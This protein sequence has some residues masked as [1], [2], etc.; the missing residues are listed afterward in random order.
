MK[1]YNYNIS[2]L[3][4]NDYHFLRCQDFSE[5]AEKINNV[6]GYNLVSKNIIVNWMCR[7][8][9]STKYNFI[10]IDRMPYSTSDSLAIE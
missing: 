9:K 5:C 7:N 3:I 1:K 2:S 10:T 6:L 8:K 4:N